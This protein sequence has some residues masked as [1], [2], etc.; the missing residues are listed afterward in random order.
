M[1]KHVEAMAAE[2]TQISI[3]EMEAFLSRGFRALKPRKSAQG[4]GQKREVV[5]DLFITDEIGIRV[6]TSLS[7]IS[8]AA[9][10]VGSDAIRV[11][12]FH[13][14][15]N[16][17]LI[18]GKAPIVKRTQGWRDNLKDRIEDCLEMYEQREMELAQRY[19][20]P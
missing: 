14:G 10:G 6:W 2:F 4:F 5:F 11:V 19:G 8:G 15:R 20:R 12:Y 9:A 13:F 3:E 17:P 7:P 16:H 1:S 18:R